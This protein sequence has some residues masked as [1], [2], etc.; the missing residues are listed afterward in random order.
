MEKAIS[1]LADEGALAQKET[2]YY[3]TLFHFFPWV[4][5]ILEE[6]LE[7][8]CG[9][10]LLGEAGCGKSALGRSILMALCRWNKKRF[11]K[12]GD[13]S[14][15]VTTEVDFL[16]GEPG[17][18]M[19]GDFLDDPGLQNILMKM[20]KSILD[21]ALYEAMRYARWG[22]TKWARHEPRG[23]ADNAYDPD[24]INSTSVAWTHITFLEFYNMVRPA[25][26]QNA[27]KTDMEAIF[28]RSAF[29]VVT[30]DLKNRV[31]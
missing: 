17:S 30:K 20:V 14:I 22:A 7:D 3:V 15:R 5:E 10:V 19:M 11:N 13:A 4:L 31:S 25:F 8:S 16:R 12:E 9:F 2:N 23:I 24:A 18:V 29:V 28:K 6:I 27:S 26:H 1:Q 21:V